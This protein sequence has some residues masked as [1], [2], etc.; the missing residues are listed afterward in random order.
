MKTDKNIIGAKH[1]QLQVGVS[2]NKRL[3]TRDSI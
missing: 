2:D 1:H 3:S